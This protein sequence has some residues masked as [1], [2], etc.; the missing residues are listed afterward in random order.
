[1]ASEPLFVTAIAP[2]QSGKSTLPLF[3]IWAKLPTRGAPDGWSRL[4]EAV[5]FEQAKVWK[6]TCLF[7][8][9]FMEHRSG[10]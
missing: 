2:R 3:D 7:K 9:K 10:E 4:A 8:L 5:T 6:D 1:M